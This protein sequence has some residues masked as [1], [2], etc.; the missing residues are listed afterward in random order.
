METSDFI[1]LKERY[2]NAQTE[3][4][5]NIYITS[6]GLSREQYMSLLRSFPRNEIAKLEAALG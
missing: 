4:K 3:E 5:I 2:D 6:E 1:K